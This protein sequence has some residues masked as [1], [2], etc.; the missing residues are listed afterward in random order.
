MNAKERIAA[1]R[2][3]NPNGTQVDCINAGVASQAT[4]YRHWPSNDPKRSRKGTAKQRKEDTVETQK[5]DDR[6]TML[7]SSD[8]KK[9]LRYLCVDDDVTA[10]DW[11][12]D[13]INAAWQKRKDV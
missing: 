7:I 6:I 2:A 11:L 8:D 4:V 1:W 13:A 12:H 5:R 9:K 3:E 10:S